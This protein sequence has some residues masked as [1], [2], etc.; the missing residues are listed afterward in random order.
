[1]SEQFCVYVRQLS[2]RCY[3]NIV[4]SLVREEIFF[5]WWWDMQ[6]RSFRT[7]T[8]R[9]ESLGYVERI[10]GHRQSSVCVLYQQSQALLTM[11]KVSAVTCSHPTVYCI[12]G[13][14]TYHL[15]FYIS[16]H[17]HASNCVLYK[18]SQDLLTICKLSAVPGTPQAVYCISSHRHSSDC[19]MYQQ[20]QAL[21]RL[22]NV[23]A[24]TGTLQTV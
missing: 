23:S 11:C 17:R 14:G 16:S 21:F 20:S 19:V 15:F 3:L 4:I 2:W 5:I 9:S 22:C 8:S 24:V 10:S 1:V 6:H 13:T 12:A 18:Q 7:A